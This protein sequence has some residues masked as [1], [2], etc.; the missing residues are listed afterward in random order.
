MEFTGRQR[1]LGCASVNRSD[2]HSAGRPVSKQNT[3]GAVRGTARGRRFYSRINQSSRC[4][5]AKK[6]REISFQL[7]QPRSSAAKNTHSAFA[8]ER[9]CSSTSSS[10]R[11]VRRYRTRS[12]PPQLRSGSVTLIAGPRVAPRPSPVARIRRHCRRYRQVDGVRETADGPRLP[13][14]L[15]CRSVIDRAD[16]RGRRRRF[17]TEGCWPAVRRTSRNRRQRTGNCPAG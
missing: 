15:T 14:T 9:R 4:D 17:P 3:D 13:G 5:G 16:E 6:R 11:L 12:I 2:V 10:S 8:A 1:P 7:P